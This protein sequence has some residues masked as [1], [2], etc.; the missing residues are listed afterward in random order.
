MRRILT[1]LSG[2]LLAVVLVGMIPTGSR[3]GI[4]GNLIVHRI[5]LWQKAAN[6]YLRHVEF[7]RWARDA[8]GGEA[9]PQRRVLRLM[10]WTVKQVQ[11]R[12]PELPFVDDHI[13]HIVLRHYGN[14]GQQA[15]VFTALTTYT[16]NEGRWWT[17]TPQDA[18]RRL[19]LSFVRS[20]DGWWVF[21]L[22]HETWFE[23][24]EGRI[25]TVVDFQQ[26]ERL[27]RHGRAPDMLEGTPY[28]AYYRD[29]DPV[30]ARSFSR[31]R[32]QMP[33]PR[34]LMALGLESDGQNLP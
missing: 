33:W 1:R 17:F 27:I 2:V 23:T 12:P 13:S 32:G 21:D 22:W 6:F 28:L 18:K 8:A 34:L 30:L 15:E 7:E 14:A 16:G 11:H 19:T 10:D 31:A 26:P 29:L 3:Q 5:P 4:D 24:P 25:A 20:D 9:D